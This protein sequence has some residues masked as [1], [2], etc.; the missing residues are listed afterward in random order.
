MSDFAQITRDYIA[1]LLRMRDEIDGTLRYLQ[2]RIEPTAGQS[3][4][5]KK[6]TEWVK[7]LLRDLGNKPTH[8]HEIARQIIDRGYRGNLQVG[9]KAGSEEHVDRIAR[10]LSGTLARDKITFEATG[11]GLY[12]LK[13]FQKS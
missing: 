11:K 6:A 2:A 1:D 4:T 9:E 3:H 13:N 10:S 7:E 12:R 5:K 8:F